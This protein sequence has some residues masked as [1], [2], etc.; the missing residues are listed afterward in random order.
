MTLEEKFD[1]PI[2]APNKYRGLLNALTILSIIGNSLGIISSIV[3]FFR[4]KTNYESIRTALEGGGIDNAPAFVKAMI[5]KE[6]LVMAEKM[7]DNRIPLLI[8]GIVSASLCLY[9][10][11]EMRKLRF[12]GYSYW[13]IGTLLN[14]IAMLLFVGVGAFVGYAWI[15]LFFTILF[16]VLYTVVVRD[17]T[18]QKN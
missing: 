16:I 11:V 13:M 2:E 9:G 17:I 6:S 5:N 4:A 15:G 10:A 12:Q 14:P 1:M 18:N 3:T 8:V 7:L